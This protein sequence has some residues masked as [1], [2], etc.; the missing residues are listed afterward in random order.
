LSKLSSKLKDN[1][2][3][4]GH[5]QKKECICNI[6]SKKANATGSI[7][8]ILTLPKTNQVNSRMMIAKNRIS[9]V[10]ILFAISSATKYKKRKKGTEFQHKYP[11]I[12]GNSTSNLFKRTLHN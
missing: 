7:L 12:K 11:E 6:N 8:T 1:R 2:R 3:R 9:F 5:K 4:N 10:D